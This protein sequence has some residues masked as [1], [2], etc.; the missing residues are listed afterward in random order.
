MVISSLSYIHQARKE[1]RH[2]ITTS[3]AYVSK[4][5]CD[6]MMN[7][8][9]SRSP[10]GPEP[11][12]QQAT[13]S[14]RRRRRGDIGTEITLTNIQVATT[15]YFLARLHEMHGDLKDIPARG[16]ESE[17]LCTRCTLES[18]TTGSARLHTMHGGRDFLESLVM[19]ENSV[20]AVVSTSF[21]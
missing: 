19:S 5:S 7:A 14:Q 18:S 13:L 21:A 8:P 2:I 11:F 12:V 17:P 4:L 1:L 20:V 6:P 15:G 9:H 10:P 16:V 3:T